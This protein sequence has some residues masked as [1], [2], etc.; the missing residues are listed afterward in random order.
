LFSD[1]L[2]LNNIFTKNG[3]FK[4]DTEIKLNAL[5]IKNLLTKYTLPNSPGF[6]DYSYCTIEHEL[7]PDVKH[8]VKYKNNNE[9]I[10]KIV[11]LFIDNYEKVF[12]KTYIFD[13]NLFDYYFKI[14]M[15]K[16]FI[17]NSINMI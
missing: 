13:Y 3:S 7:F 16:P 8:Y 11:L 17:I 6:L 14:I 12:N 4:Y 5:F 2:N 10:K 15:K 1:L 9:L